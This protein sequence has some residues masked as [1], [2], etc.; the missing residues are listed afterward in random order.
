MGALPKS[1]LWVRRCLCR[2]YKAR[3]THEFEQTHP[4]PIGETVTV[5]SLPIGSPP[6]IEGHAVIRGIARGRHRYFMCFDRDPILRERT[7]HSA[8][9]RDPDAFLQVLLDL[10]RASNAPAVEEFFCVDDK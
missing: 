4:I 8:Y 9:Q 2:R 6:R 3:L 5:L 10:W 1:Y 7:A